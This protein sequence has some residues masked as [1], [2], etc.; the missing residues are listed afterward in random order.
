MDRRLRTIEWAAVL[1]VLIAI[2]AITFWPTRVDAGA[3]GA[4]SALFRR[5]HAD[6]VPAFVD[7]D[8]LQSVANVVMFLPFG[9]LVASVAMRPLW[10]VSGVIG[11]TLSLVVESGQAIFLPA[12]LA[13]VGD[14]A[15]NTAGAL[16]GGAAVWALRT[17]RDR[18][19][20]TSKGMRA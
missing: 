13:S 11:L 8:L 19:R 5:W 17:A 3:D 16:L 10:W 15:T 1:V 12:R 9:A 20:R 2:L 6:G 18:R 4:L 7:Y 14:L